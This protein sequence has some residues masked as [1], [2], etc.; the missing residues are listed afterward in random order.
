MKDAT[1]VS[2][3]R[4][5][6][7]P[8]FDGVDIPEISPS[9]HSQL[10]R[11]TF[12]VVYLTTNTTLGVSRAVKALW[13]SKRAL[14]EADMLHRVQNHKGVTRVYATHTNSHLLL[15]EMELCAGGTLND[16]LAKG[17]YRR[18]IPLFQNHCL[19][20]VSAID[21]CHKQGVFHRDIKPQY[22]L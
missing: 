2:N 15:I 11:G 1:P 5:R 17:S 20:L 4:S 3:K 9:F 13:N 12:G 14:R 22:A 16:Y 21:F 18:N 19:Q 8:L 6:S 10:G 7:L